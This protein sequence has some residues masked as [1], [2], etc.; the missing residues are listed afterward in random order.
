MAKI[1]YH[2]EKVV[3]YVLSTLKTHFDMQFLMMVI[4]KLL[5]NICKRGQLY[6]II[7]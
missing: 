5:T 3:M 1:L 6:C 2:I 4:S 7:L